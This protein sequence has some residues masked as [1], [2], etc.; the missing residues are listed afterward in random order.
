MENTQY[1]LLSTIMFFIPN[2]VRAKGR[3]ISNDELIRMSEVIAIVDVTGIE[4][5]PLDPARR[6]EAEHHSPTNYHAAIIECIAGPC[7][8]ELVFFDAT[9]TDI[10]KGQPY[11]V[12]L[13][14]A[15]SAQMPPTGVNRAQSYHRIQDTNVEWAAPGLRTSFALLSDVIA[16]IHKTL[17]VPP[18]PLKK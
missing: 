18:S 7:Q 3:H 1:L 5:I 6:Y 13:H 12:F 11:L 14:K 8:H 9:R 16:E 17:A 4:R 10:T 2:S 15:R